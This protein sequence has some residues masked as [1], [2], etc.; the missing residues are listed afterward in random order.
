MYTMMSSANNDSFTSSFPI[1][2]P[3]IFFPCPIAVG[4]TSNTMLNRSG[5]SGQPCLVP[6]LS[7]KVFSFCPLSMMLV[8][9]FLSMAFICWVMLPL[10]P[11]CWVFFFY[12]KWVLDFIKC[13]FSIYW[14]DHIILLHHFLC[15]VLCLLTCEYCTIFASLG[16]IPL[17]HGV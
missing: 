17:D 15:G 1:W 3:L 10:F 13:F 5:E 14:Y 4:R 6:D 9:G 2:M 8:V 11:L 16:W 7:G 12:H